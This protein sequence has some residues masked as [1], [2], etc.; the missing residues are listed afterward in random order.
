[1]PKR[2]TSAEFGLRIFGLIA[3]AFLVLSGCSKKEEIPASKPLSSTPKPVAQPEKKDSTQSPSETRTSA[4]SSVSMP[5]TQL[6]PEARRKRNLEWLRILKHG[7]PEQQQRVQQEINKLPSKQVDEIMD[8][9]P[10]VK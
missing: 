2:F 8:L 5:K 6:S 1:M 3:L 4:P 7:T 9:Y 10:Q